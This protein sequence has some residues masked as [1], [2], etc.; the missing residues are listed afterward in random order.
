[1]FREHARIAVPHE[2]GHGDWVYSVLERLGRP[3]MSQGVKG[4]ALAE[5]LLHGGEAAIHGERARALQNG[6]ARAGVR[7][8]GR[9]VICTCL[10]KA[11]AMRLSMARLWP[12]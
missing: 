9:N 7:P 8:S 12:S 6:Q 11:A 2:H 3:G 5:F 4:V 1:M 10:C